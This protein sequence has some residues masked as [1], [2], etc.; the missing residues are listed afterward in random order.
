[1]SS[2]AE[3]STGQ[4]EKFRGK[5]QLVKSKNFGLG[6]VKRKWESQSDIYLIYFMGTAKI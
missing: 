1:M 5:N 3:E 4:V 2:F 6:S